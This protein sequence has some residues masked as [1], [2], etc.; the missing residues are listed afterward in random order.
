MRRALLLLVVLATPTFA[1]N[2]T[3]SVPAQQNQRAVPEPS[4]PQSC[5][6]VQDPNSHVVRNAI[7]FGGT[8]VLVGLASKR[9][10]VVDTV[11]YT[12]PKLKLKGK[13]V[14]E[15]SKSGVRVVTVPKNYSE[16]DVQQARASCVTTPDEAKAPPAG[17]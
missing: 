1:Q 17:L 11:N 2:T 7:L 5:L 4:K 3:P 6:M 16:R 14:D 13:E 15:I 10:T 9:Y 12:A 8:G